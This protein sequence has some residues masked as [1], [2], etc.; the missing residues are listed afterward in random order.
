MDGDQPSSTILNHSKTRHIVYMIKCAESSTSQVE[1]EGNVMFAVLC[2][3]VIP[4]DAWQPIINMFDIN[5]DNDMLTFML[6]SGKLVSHKF[7]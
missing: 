4:T 3:S 2:Y 1:F 5:T 6:T 7:H